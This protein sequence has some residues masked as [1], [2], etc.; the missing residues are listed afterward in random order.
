MALQPLDSHHDCGI[1]LVVAFLLWDLGREMTRPVVT[2][3][4]A[5]SG[6]GVDK[7][8]QEI[9]EKRLHPH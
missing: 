9:L 3:L 8:A 6:D 1:E 2:S 7:G 4:Q 5:Q